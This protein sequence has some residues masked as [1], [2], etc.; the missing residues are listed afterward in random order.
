[1]RA[2]NNWFVY[3]TGTVC[4][5]LFDRTRNLGGVHHVCYTCIPNLSFC[6]CRIPNG[7]GLV[8]KIQVLF[9]VGGGAIQLYG[10]ARGAI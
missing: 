5:A 2:Y 6:F 1:M 7:G 4:P 9:L 3:S 10:R 8:P